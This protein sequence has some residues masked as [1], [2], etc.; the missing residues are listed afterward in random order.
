MIEE[1]WRD[2]DGFNGMYRISSLGRIWSNSSCSRGHKFIKGSVDKKQGYRYVKLWRDGKKYKRYVHRLMASYFIS[3]PENKPQVDH[4]NTNR[5]DN[6][7]ENLRWVTKKENSNNPLT[8]IHISRS[9]QGH[10]RTPTKA[11]QAAKIKIAKVDANGN[12][13]AIYESISDAAKEN[14]LN[15]SYLSVK[16]KEGVFYKGFKWLKYDRTRK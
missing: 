4:I 11:I 6:R 13:V 7:L 15:Q 14:G 8:R 9:Q 3:N 1:V 16:I 12:T 2:I 10:G 5:L